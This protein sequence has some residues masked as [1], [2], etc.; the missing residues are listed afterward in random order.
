MDI[1]YRIILIADL[2]VEINQNCDKLDDIEKRRI[3]VNESYR[4]K[5]AD[6]HLYKFAP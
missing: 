3:V 1:L 5:S 6:L 4:D 2:S